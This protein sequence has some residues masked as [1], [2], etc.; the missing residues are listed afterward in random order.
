MDRVEK[1]RE[2]IKVLNEIN[3]LK[4]P[5]PVYWLKKKKVTLIPVEPKYSIFIGSGLLYSNELGA[6]YRNDQ[7]RS[8]TI[9]YGC[10]ESG[11]EERVFK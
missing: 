1:R 2:R 3:K 10:S 8:L 11:S 9:E 7:F 4:V 6:Y 5:I